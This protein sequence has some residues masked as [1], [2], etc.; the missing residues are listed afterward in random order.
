MHWPVHIF[1]VVLTVL[2]AVEAT[3]SASHD[4]GP[5]LAATWNE[6]SMRW[7]AAGGGISGGGRK[8][9][10]ISLG[11]KCAYCGGEFGSLAGMDCHSRHPD[12][13]G[14]PCA[15]PMNSKSMLLTQ[16]GD[17][18]TGTLRIHD[19]LGVCP[20]M[21]FF[22]FPVYPVCTL[23]HPFPCNN[24]YKVNNGNNIGIIV[25]NVKQIVLGNP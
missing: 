3:S 16:R 13:I 11:F 15:D 4:Q 5:G 2:H 25:H 18:Y 19:T 9:L 10:P 6:H 20:Y 1:Y 22:C 8:T 7:S 17:S 24:E 21:H 14:T 12:S 23:P